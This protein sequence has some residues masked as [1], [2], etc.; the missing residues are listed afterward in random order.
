V[1]L[2]RQTCYEQRRNIG[3]RPI[4]SSD[5]PGGYNP[6]RFF[7]EAVL[8]QA[9]ATPHLLSLVCR[10]EQKCVQHSTSG[11]RN[12]TFGCKTLRTM[13]GSGHIELLL[14]GCASFL[15][16]KEKNDDG[17]YVSSRL[18]LPSACFGALLRA[19]PPWSV[20]K[21]ARALSLV[22]DVLSVRL[23]QSRS[24]VLP[25]LCTQYASV[26]ELPKPGT[27]GDTL[28]FRF[29]YQRASTLVFSLDPGSRLPSS[30][31]RLKRVGSF[32]VRSFASAWSCL[33]CLPQTHPRLVEA[34]RFVLNVVGVI[35]RCDFGPPPC[36]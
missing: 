22:P 21:G 7:D 31:S 17:Y 3:Y 30:T 33:M 27:L 23:S 6:R 20:G 15:V 5:S 25:S 2:L 16:R 32:V 4:Y 18:C 29:L 24:W 26:F 19:F 28:M 11:L 35:I 8:M 1:E 9:V 14:S 10:P 12:V 13:S 36:G 34:A